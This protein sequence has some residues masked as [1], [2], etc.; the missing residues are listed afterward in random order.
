MSW[1]CPH[2]DFSTAATVKPPVHCVCGHVD[3]TPGTPQDPVPPSIL[4]MGRNYARAYIRWRAARPPRPVRSDQD[5]EAI[6]EI[7]RDCEKYEEHTG[8]CTAC[9]CPVSKGSVIGDK[10]KWA[11]EHCPLGKW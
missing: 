6:R 7:C 1:K 4:Q 10:V 3:Y 9:R 2:C 11:T 8:K 5:V